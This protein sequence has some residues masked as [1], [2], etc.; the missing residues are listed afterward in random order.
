MSKLQQANSDLLRVL[1]KTTIQGELHEKDL[2]QITG[3]ANVVRFD[4]Y[5]TFRFH[6]Q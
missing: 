2:E 1:D 6:V 5:K 4:P 3:G